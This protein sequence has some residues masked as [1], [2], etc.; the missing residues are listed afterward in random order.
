MKIVIAENENLPQK[1][2]TLISEYDAAVEIISAAENIEKTAQYPGIQPT[3]YKKRFLGKVGQRLFFIDA[4]DIAFFR[5]DNKIVH[6][7][8]KEGNRYIVDHTME[9]L[10]SQLNP[11]NFFR[12]SRKFIVNIDA[13]QQVKPYYN[14][15]LKLSLKGTAAT[16]DMVISRDRVASFRMWAEA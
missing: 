6:V 5:A 14:S 1:I 8:D 3:R 10:E 4:Q 7:V 11:E 9:K 16:E 2:K 12:L 15:R 13:I